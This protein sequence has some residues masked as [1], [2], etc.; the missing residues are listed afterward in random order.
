MKM[1]YA[2]RK[3]PRA[4]FHHYSAG[5]YFVTICT[6]NRHH[7]FGEITDGEIQL[8]PLGQYASEML[9]HLPQRF[10]YVDVSDYVVMPNHVHAIIGVHPDDLDDG[11]LPAE[12][13]ALS[14]VVGCF[15]QAVTS[16]ARRHGYD[17]AWQSRYHDRIIRNREEFDLISD[18]IRKNVG[19]WQQDCFHT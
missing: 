7:F 18:Y 13:T 12:R 8:T 14:V 11:A 15:K 16:F 10:P 5:D 4:Y 9:A 19:R 6:R 17:F 2:K 1:E 3:S